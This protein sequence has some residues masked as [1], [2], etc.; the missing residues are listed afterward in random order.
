MEKPLKFI[1]YGKW[2]KLFAKKL[3]GFEVEVCYDIAEN[4]G[5]ANATMLEE[6]QQK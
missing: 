5:D 6:F 4:V 2:E 3:R 1:G